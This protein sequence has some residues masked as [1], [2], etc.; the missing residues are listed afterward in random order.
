MSIELPPRNRLA[1]IVRALETAAAR[2]PEDE[3][4]RA[5]LSSCG[6]RLARLDAFI[7]DP[8]AFEAAAGTT[9]FNGISY[10]LNELT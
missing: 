7:D 5:H 9:R 10:A 2:R 4:V 8:A 3:V 6:L 1:G